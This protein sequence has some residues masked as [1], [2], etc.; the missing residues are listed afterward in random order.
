M[1]RKDKT[2]APDSKPI[3][4]TLVLA[5][6]GEDD[7]PAKIAVHAVDPAGAILETVIAADRDQIAF[8]GDTLAAARKIAITEATKTPDP[9]MIRAAFAVPPAQLAQ[10][11][12]THGE[13]RL[14]ANRW[15]PAL[16]FGNCVDGRVRKCWWGP[17][18]AQAINSGIAARNA[19][20]DALTPLSHAG[21]KAA[22]IE[23]QPLIPWLPVLRCKPICDGLVEIYERIC[24][25][26]PIVTPPILTTLR[27]RLREMIHQKPK[28]KF[29]PVPPVLDQGPMPA[30]AAALFV[31]GALV[32]DRVEAEADLAFLDSADFAEAR[33]FVLERP[34]FWHHFCTCG[35]VAYKGATLIGPG[36][37]FSHC[38]K[39][40]I[41]LPGHC[42]REY[43]FRVRQVING[44]SVVIYDG[45]AA[46]QWFDD[47]DDITLN[48]YHPQAV[49]CEDDA[50]PVPTDAPYAMLERIGAT[51][52]WNLKTPE[53]DGW[54]QTA[55]PEYNDGLV[56]PAA[57]VAAARGV[58]RNRNWGGTLHLR[59]L[60]TE[61][62]RAIGARFYRVR[63][64]RANAAGNPTGTAHYLETPISWI[65]H[66]SAGG[67]PPD[68][69]VK[70]KQLNLEGDP[71]FYAI[72]YLADATWKSGQYHAV[73][74]TTGFD[75]GRHLVTLELYDQNQNRIIPTNAADGTGA[76]TAL[77]FTYEWWHDDA[78]EGMPGTTTNVPFAG[79]TH[80]FWWDNRDC[81]ADV[82]SLLNSGLSSSD[83][84]QFM[85]GTENSSFAA[86]IDAYH[87][88]DWFLLSWRLR[89]WRGLNGPVSL[90]DSGVVNAD[91]VTSASATFG[92]MLGSH[93]K[94][95]FSLDLQ[96]DTKAFNGFST[97]H[98]LD[99]Y[100][101]ASFA[102]D[103]S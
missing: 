47:D 3:A 27:A 34:R 57:S 76:D 49:D 103:V 32:E 92:A 18:F 99:A 44:Q 25:C 96:V 9:D 36:G 64:S 37:N 75:D 86:E 80:M 71:S 60:F 93:E 88:H 14:S 77:Q 59:Y 102:L 95:T 46:N 51:D 35:T 74:D 42:H 6:L 13:W 41:F 38:Y 53:P 101:I 8:S 2:P 22:R 4:L 50:T 90:L 69:Q 91:P 72:P 1:P 7:G 100:D 83:E 54:N 68:I 11:A 62:L 21:I 29:P 15:R 12:E 89:W 40:Q 23:A 82:L 70:S 39:S 48:S 19:R 33:A 66:E 87:P 10:W 73:L 63:V 81:V 97:L 84:C 28:P 31:S 5:D 43:A 55:F 79:L 45:V 30:E 58:G 24:C 26:T 94:C 65:Y 98:H 52:A 17:I 16:T 56:F 85:S 61:P 78:T 20:L 67:F